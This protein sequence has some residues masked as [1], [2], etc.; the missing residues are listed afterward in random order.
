MY[1]NLIF[2]FSENQKNNFGTFENHHRGPYFDGAIFASWKQKI[3]IHILGHNPAVLA[4][5]VNSSR[6]EKNK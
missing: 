4:C 3:K 1:K 5:K 2:L 6:M